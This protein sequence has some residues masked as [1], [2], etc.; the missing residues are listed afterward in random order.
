MRKDFSQVES[1]KDKEV[2]NVS[3]SKHEKENA[4]LELKN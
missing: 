3:I 4:A 2:S 1:S